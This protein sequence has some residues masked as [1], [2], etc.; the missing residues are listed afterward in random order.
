MLFSNTVT[1]SGG[2]EAIQKRSGETSM[3]EKK[4]RRCSEE[5]EKG[6]GYEGAMQTKART[7]RERD[8]GDDAMEVRSKRDSSD[9][10]IRDS[11][12]AIVL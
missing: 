3:V 6:G 7:K 8:S 1:L 9:D 12:R 5:T 11:I 4:T 10:A 2:S